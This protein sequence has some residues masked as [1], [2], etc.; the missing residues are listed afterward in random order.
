MNLFF[1]KLFGILENTNKMEEK[2]NKLFAEFIHYKRFERSEEYAEYKK[3]FQIVKSADFQE[4][5][6]QLKTIKY[7]DTQEYQDLNSF[8]QLEKNADLRFYFQTL[9]SR[10]LSD[11]LAFKETKEYYKLSDKAA[12]AQ[13]PE[14][15]RYKDFENSKE[16][17]NY[18]RFHNSFLVQEYNRLKEKISSPEFKRSNA[19]WQDGNRWILSEEYAQEK[20][21]Y[22]IL[23]SEDG[24]YY[25]STN[26][27]KFDRIGNLEIYKKDNFNYRSLSE[28]PWKAGY[29]YNNANVK[30]VFSYANER[31]ANTGGKNVSLGNGLV[32]NTKRQNH[33]ATT[34]DTAKGFVEKDFDFTSDVVSGYNMV[35]EEY[36]GIR[37]KMRC[38][39]NVNHAFW[40]T[41]GNKLPHI[42]VA[43]IKGKE[44]EVGVH[45]AR[46][47]YYYTTVKGI[48][49][50]DYYIYSIYQQ[51]GFLIWKIN[52]IEVFRTKNII[53]EVRFSP[54]FSSFIPAD[55]TDATEGRLEVEWIEVYK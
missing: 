53:S 42:N 7:K 33:R 5:R 30:T 24:K 23:N 29:H 11:F 2:D 40:L 46:G 49:P 6:K 44:I 15:Q 1:K 19:F 32:I 8:E 27:R 10:Q 22:D 34:W 51:N 12:L 38:L 35:E 45:D 21:F 48:N 18:V 14:L 4:K 17:L 20:R 43:L 28:S 39:G 3:L 36:C 26:P 55:K 37:V 9:N 25:F 16:Y 54:C 13:S 47:D 52:N 31:Q 41:S 50:A